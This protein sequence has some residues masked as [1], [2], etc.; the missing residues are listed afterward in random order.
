MSI[1]QTPYPKPS[2]GAF[3]RSMGGISATIVFILVV[4]QPFGTS[5]FEHPYKYLLLSGYGF[6]IFLTGVL[7]FSIS[8]WLIS[9]QRLDRWSVFDEVVYL[10]FI[11]I[12]CQVVC[13][14]YWAYLFS[15]GFKWNQFWFFFR[16]ASTVSVVPVS[17]YLLFIYQKY[18]EVKFLSTVS[19]RTTTTPAEKQNNLLLVS[20]AGKNE[21]LKLHMDDLFLV[22]SEDNYVILY[23][24]ENNHVTKR[25]L[26]NTLTEIELQ[27]GP[28]FFRCHRSYIINPNKI[29][30]IEGNITNTRINI[31]DV[32]IKIPVSR[33]LVEKV[34]SFISDK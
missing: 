31:A 3:I 23:L 29:Q 4:F 32:D 26:R 28:A 12:L 14:M 7:F 30:T 34:K 9:D 6:I 16:M 15:S 2:F 10:F 20:G 8:T 25:M 33:S 1:T 24:K 22:K 18:R 21:N 19:D 17:V 5:D 13:Y 11:I 27:L